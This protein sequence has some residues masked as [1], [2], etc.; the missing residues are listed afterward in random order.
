MQRLGFRP[1][2][3][4]AM[5]I[6]HYALGTLHLQAWLPCCHGA[7]RAVMTAVVA[8]HVAMAAMQKETPSAS[9]CPA[10]VID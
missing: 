8:K 3:G 7:E 9:V 5:M 6:C 4:T 1:G 10:D 2:L